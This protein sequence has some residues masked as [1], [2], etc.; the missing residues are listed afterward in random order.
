MD[1]KHE[2]HYHIRWSS[3]KLDWER[4]GSQAEAESG[5]KKLMQYRETYRIEERGELCRRCPE[6]VRAKMRQAQNPYDW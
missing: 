4:F 1:R 2:V 3:G 6:V 5:S